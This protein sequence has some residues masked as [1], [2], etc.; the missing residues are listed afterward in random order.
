MQEQQELLSISDFVVTLW[1]RKLIFLVVFVLI[2]AAAVAYI[3][4]AKKTYRLMGTINVG[5]FQRLLIEEGEFVANKLEDYSFIKSA[6]AEGGVEVDMPVSRLRR[7]IKADVINEIKKIDDVGLVQLTVDFKDQQK[8][9]EI[10]KALTDKLIAEHRVLVE[11]SVAEFNKMEEAFWKNEKEVR[12][13]LESDKAYVYKGMENPKASET[14]PA[15]LLAQ[16]SVS[17]KKSYLKE[18]VKDIYYLR[19]EGHSATRSYVTK[20]AAE[21]KVPDEHHKPKAL[22]TLIL[23]LVVASIAA[24]SAAL[25]IDVYKRFI[26]PKLG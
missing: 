9:F 18:L 7:L 21:P 3:K 25:S 6:L 23:A 14:V 2:M 15:H 19:I 13:S 17:E 5:R 26:Q 11:Q 8:C 24:T 1:R 20:L 16:H 22:I 10:Y 12:D 4:L